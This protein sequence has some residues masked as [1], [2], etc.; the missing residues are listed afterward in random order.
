MDWTQFESLSYEVLVRDDLPRL[1]KLG[2]VADAGADAVEESF[3]QD[4]YPLSTVVN[5]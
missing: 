1:R 3:L 4:E 5:V 2:G